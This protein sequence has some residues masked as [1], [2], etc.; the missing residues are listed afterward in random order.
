MDKYSE[1]I[2]KAMKGKKVLSVELDGF[3]IAIRFTDGTTFKFNASDG[4]YSTY[5][6][7]RGEE[8]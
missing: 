4:G 1:T 6:L 5:A 7:K 2:A 3:G 8:R